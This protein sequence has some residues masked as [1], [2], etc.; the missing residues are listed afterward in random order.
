MISFEAIK[1]KEI[2]EAKTPK[3]NTRP[4]ESGIT[5]KNKESQNH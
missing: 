4:I 1:N 2:F 3:N 5:N